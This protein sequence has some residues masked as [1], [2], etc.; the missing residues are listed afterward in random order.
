MNKIT[1]NMVG[2][3]W[4][5]CG[6]CTAPAVVFVGLSSRSTWNMAGTSCM[7]KSVG[8]NR[9]SLFVVPL[10]YAVCVVS[11]SSAAILV[12]FEGFGT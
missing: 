8:R 2:P 5:P 11:C 6:A 1:S 3:W 9:R 7:R 10:V 12:H 4:C